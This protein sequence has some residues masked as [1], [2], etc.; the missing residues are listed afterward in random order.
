MDFL[1]N[2]NIT[3]K[4]WSLSLIP[5]AGLCMV[6]VT[7]LSDI[8]SIEAEIEAI[9]EED[10]P[11]TQMVTTIT[12]H[13]L[14]MGIMMERA[15][16]FG[17]VAGASQHAAEKLAEAEHEF[18]AIGKKVIH[19]IEEGGKLLGQMI[20]HAATEEEKETFTE[21]NKQLDEILAE[22]KSFESHVEHIFVLLEEGKI[23]EAMEQGEVA[24][25]E[26][27][28]LITEM[29]MFLKHV[30]ELTLEKTVQAENDAKRAMTVISLLVMV[31]L[32]V[33]LTLSFL[34]SRGII[35]PIKMM[36]ETARE[37]RDGDGDLTRRLPDLGNDEVGQTATAFNGFVENI[38]NVLTEVRDAVE[39]IT[40]ASQ[41]VSA[42]AQNLSQG[43]SEQA[44]SV[45]ETGASMEEMA[46]T[47][48]RNTENAHQTDR[49]ASNS[50]KDARNGGQA[51]EETVNAM[52][53]IADKIGLIEDIA[54]KTNLLALN[55]AIEAA[56]AGE[57]GKGFAVVADEVRKL[58]ERSQ[59][60]AQDI[61]SLSANSLGVSERAGALLRELVPNIEETADLVQQIAAASQE[62]SESV[63]Q[64]NGAVG[65]LDK[66]SQTN[67]ASSEELA[68]TSEEL[69]AQSDQLRQTIQF[70]KLGNESGRRNAA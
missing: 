54:Y 59:Q 44:A 36:L 8:N 28:K 20:S 23:T 5:L 49:I 48:A 6:A 38:Q 15:L 63:S 46:G 24:E 62:Q 70:F 53:E 9:A 47:I 1:S 66:V 41:Q 56:R 13:Q 19:E 17:E 69:T 12:E 26:E 30:G 68:A 3:K 35:N 42:T 34:V 27:D 11:L 33:A 7:A 21:M 32:G 57:H 18:T 60:S 25:H 65:Q 4:V 45:E 37:L 14:E 52:R 31:S 43:A 16:R 39:N 51:V 22:T 67:A 58:A 61:S 10:M 29:E 64:V 50:A 2:I 40:D 55:A